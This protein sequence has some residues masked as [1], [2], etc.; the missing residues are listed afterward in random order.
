MKKYVH[1]RKVGETKQRIEVAHTEVD[2]EFEI[3]MAIQMSK[4]EV[5]H[6]TQSIPV[7]YTK[8]DEQMI[9]TVYEIPRNNLVYTSY[10]NSN[11]QETSQKIINKN[12]SNSND[13]LQSDSNN[14][15]NINKYYY[16]NRNKIISR[17]PNIHHYSEKYNFKESYPNRYVNNIPINGGKIENYYENKISND[18]QYL[19]TVSLAKK[20]L[21]KNQNLPA[22]NEEIVNNRYAEEIEIDEND[23]VENKK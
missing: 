9:T 11:T 8:I 7:G 6:S 4:L 19:I 3:P 22:R 18:G 10:D 12:I 13:Y 15:I 16:F 1:H 14:N 5:S 23:E 2:N 17:S 20:V 21:D